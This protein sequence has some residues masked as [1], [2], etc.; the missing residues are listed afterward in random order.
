MHCDE[1]REKHKVNETEFV[2]S[3]AGYVIQCNS[4]PSKLYFSL[5]LGSDA[6]CVSIKLLV[7]KNIE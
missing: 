4:F 2:L 3:R 1:C 5:K 6:V 7:K